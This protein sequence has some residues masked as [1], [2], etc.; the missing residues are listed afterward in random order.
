VTTSAAVTEGARNEGP[1]TPGEVFVFPMSLAQ[2]RL[3]LIERL[4]SA[5]SLFTLS[6]L[7]RLPEPVDVEVLAG[8]LDVLVQRHETLRTTFDLVDGRP[9]QL[10]HPHLRVEL[11]VR[12]LTDVGAA[13]RE[14]A[15]VRLADEL[16]QQPFDL[17]RGPLVRATVLHLGPDEHLFSLCMHHL[18]SDGWSM[19]IFWR[20]LALACQDVAAGRSVALPELAVQYADYAVWQR[21]WL[22][23]GA[24]DTQLEYWRRQLADL[25]P[26]LE[27]PADRPR[28]SVLSHRGT[29]IHVD[30]PPAVVATA[31]QLASQAGATLFM[32][33]LAATQTWLHRITGA[34]DLV[35]GSYLAGRQ[36]PETESM[37]GFFLNTVV[38]RGDLTGHPTFLEVL[39]RTRR[40]ALDAYAH[41]DVPFTTLVHELQPHRDP[42]R[43][44][45]FQVMMQLNNV[46]TLEELT[47]EQPS[48]ALPTGRTASAFDLSLGFQR[49]HAGGLTAEVE[50][51]SDLF[52]A[53]TVRGFADALVVLLTDAVA[54]PDVPVAELVLVDDG[55]RA[56]LLHDWGER[57]VEL[58][59]SVSLCDLFAQQVLARPES[60]AFR[61]ESATV[62]YAELDAQSTRLAARLRAAGADVERTVAVLLPRGLQAPVALLA[63]LK[64]GAAYVPIAADHPPARVKRIL[65]DAH[66]AALVT[67]TALAAQLDLPFGVTVVALDAADAEPAGPAATLP[68]THSSPNDLAYVLYTSGSTGAPKGVAVEHRQVL[69]RLQWMWREHPFGADEVACQKTSLSFVDS[70]WELLGPLLAGVPTVVLGDEVVRDPQRLVR[71]LRRERVTRLWLVPHLLRALVD[72]VPDLARKLPDLTFWVCSGA[73]LSPD[74]VVRFR[75]VMPNATLY[76]LYGTTE[77]WDAAWWDPTTSSPPAWRTPIGQPIDNVRLRVLDPELQLLPVGVPGQLYV[78]GVGLARGYA[79]DDVLTKQ[80]FIDDPFAPGERLYASGDTVRWLP[81]GD[82]EFVARSDSALDVNGY[83]VDP[84]EV[85]EA[86]RSLSGVRDA[87][88]STSPD[89]NG[90]TRIVAHLEQPEGTVLVADVRRAL[91]DTLPQYMLPTEVVCLPEF[92]L[93]ASGKVD[94]NALPRPASVPSSA[95]V[96]QAGLRSD[97]ERAI[98]AVWCE[99]LGTTSVGRDE[100]FFDIGGYSLLLVTVHEQLRQEVDADLSLTDMFAFPTI[101]ALAG[102]S[103]RRAP[104]TVR[105]R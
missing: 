47:T 93:T 57:P 43:N 70:L 33:L 63:T 15:A 26:I 102:R 23:D 98:A 50:F 5:G 41:Q 9:A 94:R 62:T 68:D 99:A 92:P 95:R 74:L 73:S 76:N 36:E 11:A 60:V 2:E 81:S 48:A 84:A 89:R 27:L 101:A 17:T 61:D 71:S 14:P 20:E 83:R 56:R 59:E 13:D 4:G 7:S 32:V 29:A 82:L 3:W 86:L 16:A 8:A 40:T 18:V 87:V 80:R 72:T 54:R 78:G 85:E 6:T 37:I 39:R 22:N 35:V 55:D 97:V 10:V 75:A 24:L 103:T 21:Q 58:D 65:D 1:A 12:D 34:D 38:L 64:A 31:E 45:L 88:A 79:G 77:V 66:P 69:N 100:N 30:V 67:E 91:R 28:P 46:P 52:E 90:L 49:T 51:S 44:P 105:T 53:A 19:G 25:P 96:T 42:S 104:A